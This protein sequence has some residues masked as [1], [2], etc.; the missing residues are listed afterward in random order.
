MRPDIGCELSA[1][2]HGVLRYA[3]GTILFASAMAA[4]P[5][6]AKA[7]GSPPHDLDKVV[8][9]SPYVIVRS[10]YEVVVTASVRRV[11]TPFINRYKPVGWWEVNSLVPQDSFQFF[12]DNSPNPGTVWDRGTD[13]AKNIGRANPIYLSNANKAEFELDFTDS[14]IELP[15]TFARTYNRN[16]DGRIGVTGG[17]WLSNLDY[18]FEGGGGNMIAWRPDGSSINFHH[19]VGQ[20][21]YYDNSAE[22]L[23][24]VEV[25]PGDTGLVV[26]W[27]DGAVERYDTVERTEN[28]SKSRIRKIENSRGVGWTF[29][30]DAP[31]A[32]LY[33][34]SAVVHTSGKRIKLEYANQK[35]VKV[36]DPAGNLYQYGGES[37]QGATYVIY[38][39]GVNL[40]YHYSAWDPYISYDREL[41]GKSYDGVRY[42]TFQWLQVPSAQKR[43]PVS[44]E[45][46]G[47]VEKYQFDFTI[48]QSDLSIAQ[49]VETNPLG[50]RTTYVFDKGKLTG[51]TG[52]PS[53][54]CL[55]SVSSITYDSNGFKDRVTDA[56][57]Y[58]TDYDYSP[59]GKLVRLVEALGTPQQR[60][61]EYKWDP[62]KGRP[63]ETTVLGLHK[64]SYRYDQGG[65]IAE[66]ATQNLSANGVSGQVRSVNYSHTYHANGKVA[67][68]TVDG[69]VTGPG[70][71]EVFTYSP[72]GNL[73]SIRDGLGNAVVYSNHNGLGLPGRVETSAGAATEY[74]YDSRG[75]VL[76]QRLVTPRGIAEV[77]NQYAHGLLVA[78]T[79]VDGVETRYFY[80]AARRLTDEYRKEPDGTYARRHYVLNAMSKPL[81]IEVSRV[82]SIP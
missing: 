44:S 5:P 13:C 3:I 29:E 80:D 10:P 76:T 68:V 20:D 53:S 50:K 31:G 62:E 32:N 36:W 40:T 69:P 42:S 47:G 75:R 18:Q 15:L 1:R 56:R 30:Y 39:D 52:H 2:G 24:Y 27:G 46:A 38:P 54:L 59:G 19:R 11:P 63:T 35:L 66:I 79:S 6:L 81:R 57:N 60:T 41:T 23:S 8:V 48:N 77:K 82:D 22:P 17:F 26:H 4:V 37:Y 71:S 43:L 61:T 14:D 25:D 55:G 74:S 9:N 16:A 73:L 12:E 70:D 67:T 45:H 51:V 72:T 78:S 65:Q 33:Q 49:A 7:S 21:K 28:S 34:P 58:I 64:I